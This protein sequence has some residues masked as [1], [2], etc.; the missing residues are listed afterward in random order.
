M[1]KRLTQ[2]VGA[3]T[4]EALSAAI[5]SH[6]APG[7]WGSL[8]VRAP[9]EEE[10][11]KAI[12]FRSWV[13]L[14]SAKLKVTQGSKARTQ[15]RAQN[16]KSLLAVLSSFLHALDP[17]T[18]GEGVLRV[19]RRSTDSGRQSAAEPSGWKQT[20]GVSVPAGIGRLQ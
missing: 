20:P 1:R 15:Q 5:R 12:G 19:G 13:I 18:Q 14:R 7:C 2:P 3:Q 6:A 17:L 9:S 8:R 16:F 4:A 10:N 11:V